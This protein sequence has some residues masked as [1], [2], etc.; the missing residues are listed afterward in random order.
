MYGK[1]GSDPKEKAFRMEGFSHPESHIHKDFVLLSFYDM[2]VMAQL[3]QKGLGPSP[4]IEIIADQQP[5]LR[6]G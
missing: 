4:D 6:K 1:R 2:H 5:I 3:F